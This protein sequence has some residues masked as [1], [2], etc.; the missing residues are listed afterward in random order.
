MN[1]LD[2]LFPK[3][4]IGCGKIGS[5][6]CLRCRKTMHPLT[7]LKCPVCEKPAFD[8]AT[9]PRCK[10][11][12]G[13]DGLTSFFRYDGIVKKAVKE[14]KYRF[15][16]DI[17]HELFDCIPQ[18]SRLSFSLIRSSYLESR[19]SCI[20]PVPL[21]ASRLRFRGFNQA[22]VIGKELSKRF[23][24]PLQRNYL[25]RKKM[26]LPQVEMKVR[27]NRLQNMKD[28]FIVRY[29]VSSSHRHAVA[30]LVDDVFTT[31]ATLR[32][33]A[34]VLKHARVKY[35]WGVTIAQ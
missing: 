17:V 31:G 8:G 22:E 29:P 15:V 16:T 6:I 2:L 12:Y 21:H 30:L 25:L 23:N 14:L 26:T 13:I 4:C 1:L 5:Y 19:L 28:V 24:I 35:V 10:T 9:H 3:R 7:I 27:E 11:R 32:S 18:F 34:S 33:A 20:L